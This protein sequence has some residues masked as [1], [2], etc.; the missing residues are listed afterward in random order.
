MKT[1]SQ[2]QTDTVSQTDTQTETGR[3]TVSR[4]LVRHSKIHRLTDRD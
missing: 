3:Q 1:D 2:T 4:S